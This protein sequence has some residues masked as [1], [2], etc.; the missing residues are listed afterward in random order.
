MTILPKFFLL[1]AGPV[2]ELHRVGLWAEVVKRAELVVPSVVLREASFWDSGEGVGRP[3]Y[4]SSDIEDGRLRVVEG[5]AQQIASVLARLDSV[6]Q[7]RVHAGELEAIA[8]LA[9]WPDECPPQFC[10][11]DQLAVVVVCLLGLSDRPISLESSFGGLG[12]VAP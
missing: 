4:L 2:I 8:A 3:I 7:E 6:V 1:D 10:V 12:W 11:A 9:H 5:T